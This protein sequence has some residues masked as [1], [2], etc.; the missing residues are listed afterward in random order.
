MDRTE[1]IN[2]FYT[3]YNEDDRLTRSRKGQLEYLTTMHYIHRF[4]PGNGTVLDIGAGTGRYSVAL[5]REGYPVT[6]VELSECN[7]ALLRQNAEGLDNLSAFRGDAVDLGRFPDDSFDLTLL[8]GPMYHL[9]EEED[10]MTAL[11][12]AIRVTKPGGC[13]ITA[14]LSIYMILYD[15]YLRG[16]LFEG[17]EENYTADYQVR[18][19]K[20]QLFTGFDV[21][22]FEAMFRELPVVHAAT[23][24]ADGVLEMV[25]GRSDFAMSDE[26]FNAFA[27]FHLAHCET[28]ELLGASAHL[29]HICRKQT[30]L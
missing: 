25:Q 16:N 2:E 26:E 28:R 4:L 29:L 19:F 11:R 18:H 22:E 23:V 30:A 6:A 27:A 10:Q 13:L 1:M 17:L 24:A 20:E 15:N 9:Y 8:M 21:T 5:A 7:L 14:F 12:E 3:G